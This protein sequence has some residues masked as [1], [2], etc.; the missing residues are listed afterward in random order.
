MANE[1]Q[2]RRLID[3]ALAYV[4]KAELQQSREAAKTKALQD[5]ANLARAGNMQAAHELAGKTMNS[6]QLID[7]TDVL[8]ELIKATKPFKK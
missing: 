2:I 4:D 8:N 6:I 3:A 5:A 7:F 1:K